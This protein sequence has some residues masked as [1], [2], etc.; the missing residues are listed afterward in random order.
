MI[1]DSMDYW[2]GRV[3]ARIEESERRHA[4]AEALARNDGTRIGVLE[5]TVASLK[6]KVA[7]YSALGA[8]AGGGLVSLLARHIPV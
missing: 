7:I 1:E 5:T 4:A 8:L 6:T 2:R 3:D